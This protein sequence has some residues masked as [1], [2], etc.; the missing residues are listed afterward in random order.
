M[1]KFSLKSKSPWE[2]ICQLSW[3]HEHVASLIRPVK[4]LDLL[5]LLLG[6]LLSVGDVNQ[7]AVSQIPH[8]VA[9]S[10]DLLVH[11]EVLGQRSQ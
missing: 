1:I 9:S 11:L 2:V 3:P 8:G 4:G 5:S 6:L 7:V 10:A